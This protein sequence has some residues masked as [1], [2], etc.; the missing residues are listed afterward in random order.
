MKHVMW[1]RKLFFTHFLFDSRENK[2]LILKKKKIVKL[3]EH[4]TPACMSFKTNRQIESLERI[5]H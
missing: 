3:I 2:T 1:T 4:A 5:F